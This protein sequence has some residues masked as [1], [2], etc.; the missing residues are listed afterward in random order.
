MTRSDIRRAYYN[1]IMALGIAMQ[2]LPEL[3]FDATIQVAEDTL[4]QLEKAVRVTMNMEDLNYAL[5]K[6]EETR[7]GLRES[8]RRDSEKSPRGDSKDGFLNSSKTRQERIDRISNPGLMTDSL[9][10]GSGRRR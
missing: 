3:P 9:H 6:I 1:L 4:T 8:S 10:H 2:G 5:R 7:R